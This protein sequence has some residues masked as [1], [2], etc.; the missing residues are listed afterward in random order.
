MN[1]MSFW[2]AKLAAYLHDPPHKPRAIAAHEDQRQSFLNRM[3]LDPEALSEFNRTN[4]WDAAAADRL[5]FP[6][7]AKR[8]LRVDWRENE[9]E[10][11][12]P[13]GGGR[14]TPSQFPAS[15]ALLEEAFV[16]ALDGI[17]TESQDWKM[18][19]IRAWRLWP[20]RSARE[21]SPHLAYVVA[22][23]RIPDH[24]LWHH[25][26]L[27]SA[28][29]GAGA[30]PA[31]LLFQIGPVQEFIAQARKTVDLWS[32]SYLLSYLIAQAM[33]AVADEIGPDAVVFP[34]MRAMPLAD[35]HWW[36]RGYLGRQKLRASHAN[37]LLMPNLPNRF[38]ALVPAQRGAEL[39]EMA[40]QAVRQAWAEIAGAVKGFLDEQFVGA[41]P[42]W[43]K[44]WAAQVGRFPVVDWV[45][46]PWGS[47]AQALQLAK[48]DI[49]PLPGGWA[50]HSLHFA[51]RWAEEFIPADQREKYGPT[52]SS[53]FAWS[54]HFAATEWKFAARKRS[55]GFAPW[56]EAGALGADGVPK[57]HLDGKNE[58]M[59]GTEHARFRDRLREICPRE[60][61][62]AQLYGALSI[63]KRLWPEHYLRA[64]LEL[65][66]GEPV[67]QPVDKIARLDNLLDDEASEE[68]TYYAVLAMDGDNLGQWLSGAAGVPLVNSL[69][70]EA[71]AY[72]R[73][74]WPQAG[75][76]L[77]PADAVP[78][79]LSPGFHAMLSEALA[80]FSL[81]CAA[82]IV[83]R[84]GGQLIY[85]GGDDVL[86]MTPADSALECAQALQLAFRGVHPEDP[87]A[88]VSKKVKE[89]LSQIFDYARHVDGFITLKRGDGLGVGRAENLKPN[90]P[91][92]VMGPKAT[93]SVGIAIGHV[94]AP[95]QD[96]IQAARAA[97]KSAKAVAGK[98]AFCLNV[99]KRSGEGVGF[100]ARW[101]AGVVIVWEE[102]SDAVH[103]LSGRFA[104]RYALLV[105]ALVIEGGSATGAR[106]APVWTAELTE[107][108]EAELRHVLRQQGGMSALQAASLA[109][110]W[111]QALIPELCPR[112]FLHF[113]MTWAFVNRQG[114][115]R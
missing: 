2:K 69:A 38:L 17:A 54:L 95:M 100:S 25:N 102:L 26:A 36:K 64:K 88:R 109:D 110:N 11:R 56:R 71:Q 114:E 89:V 40:E 55:R 104:Y 113:W 15:S 93:A 28:F 45:V 20:E 6:N 18:N 115:A 14:L 74:Y 96:T 43:D 30:A 47:T 97:E 41:F 73:Q 81:Y 84:F 60:F 39:A 78:R 3:G 83:T 50:Q 23:T 46:H 106:Y 61:K 77:P 22:D 13:L 7:S 59:G 42:G 19:F 65:P 58:A 48:Q 112:N 75:V 44:N 99:L 108:V 29:C 101:S 66:S 82:P 72:F 24:T 87:T 53:G 80:N 107:S 62:G 98:G 33:L 34:Q 85:A 67:F 32:G 111:R 79:P 12:H 103:D 49:P 90:W 86:A 37:E 105:K 76:G 4:D 52:S 31:F 94:R 10:F 51:Q 9:W 70:P 91:L 92:P 8:G 5:I 68:S 27:A 16:S 57:D 63:I 35:H 1:D 21:K